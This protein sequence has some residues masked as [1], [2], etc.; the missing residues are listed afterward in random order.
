MH[1]GRLPIRAHHL[2][3]GAANPFAIGRDQGRP[4]TRVSS[5]RASK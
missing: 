2:Q 4:K 3:A 1:S 5:S